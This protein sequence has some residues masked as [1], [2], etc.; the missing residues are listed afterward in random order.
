MNQDLLAERRRRALRRFM[1][2]HQLVPKDWAKN[3]GLPNANSIYNF[4][5][6]RSKSLSQDTYERLARVVP[7]TTVS[8]LTGETNYIPAD[9]LSWVTVMGVVKLGIFTEEL[10]PQE[11]RYRVAV[12]AV[13]KDVPGLH[14]IVVE[15]DSADLIYPMGT[16]LICTPFKHQGRTALVNR[17]RVIVQRKSDE[18]VETSVREVEVKEDGKI[19]LWLRSSN[20]NMQGAI[21]VPK[22]SLT[23]KFHTPDGMAVEIASVVVASYRPEI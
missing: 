20:P 16:V 23:G 4:L 21:E 18:G 8:V 11:K 2:E 3:A 9:D 19:W 15:D 7:G 1:A 10:L 14:G 22:R 13:H 17:R 6:G 5:A 12:P